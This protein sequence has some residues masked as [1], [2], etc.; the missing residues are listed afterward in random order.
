[1]SPARNAL[2]TYG[3]LFVCSDD[4]CQ[5]CRLLPAANHPGR[6]QL[7]QDKMPADAV[8]K[9]DFSNNIDHEFSNLNASERRLSSS[10]ACAYGHPAGMSVTDRVAGLEADHAS[11]VRIATLSVRRVIT[12]CIGINSGFDAPVQI[13]LPGQHSGLDS[14]QLA[15]EKCRCPRATG[16][17]QL[18]LQLATASR[19]TSMTLGLENETRQARA[20]VRLGAGGVKRRIASSRCE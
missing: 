11:L 9:K 17:T 12:C 8:R 6:F 15:G 1:L 13:S 4:A 19:I 5:T 3:W 16:F 20:T 18:R 10:R 2:N 14:N 7:Q